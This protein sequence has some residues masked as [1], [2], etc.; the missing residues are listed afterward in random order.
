MRS[1]MFAVA[2]GMIA[3]LA[4]VGGMSSDM[5]DET[6]TAEVRPFDPRP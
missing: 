3:A 6:V 4:A 5:E 1:L 2:L